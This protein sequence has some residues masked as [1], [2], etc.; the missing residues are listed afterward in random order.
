LITGD[1]IELDVEERKLNIVGIKGQKMSEDE[2]SKVLSERKEKWI[3]PKPRYSK[4]VLR[5]FREHAAS[6][7]EGAYL[8]Y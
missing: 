8:K 7:M 6:P 3:A 5:L 1:L 4:G 2:I